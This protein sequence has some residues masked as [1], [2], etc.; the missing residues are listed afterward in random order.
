MDGFEYMCNLAIKDYMKARRVSAD[1]MAA[2]LHIT[3]GTFYAKLCGRRPWKHRELRT[4]ALE[5]VKIPPLDAPLGVS[6][7]SK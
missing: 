4:L 1:S 7:A 6:S 3:R 2:T 5:G